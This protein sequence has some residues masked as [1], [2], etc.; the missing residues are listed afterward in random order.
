MRFAPR[1]DFRFIGGVFTLTVLGSG[2]AGNCALVTTDHCRLLV[3]AGLSA[4]Q[5][6]ERLALLDLAPEQL[7]AVLLT[8][9]HGDH[10]RALDVLCRR[11]KDVPIYCNALTAEILRRDSECLKSHRHWRVFTTGTDF[12][13]KDV[14]VQTF[15][16]PHDAVEPV[17]YMFHHGRAALGYLTDLGFATK[18]VHERVREATTLLIETNHDTALLNA[19]TRRPWSVK[20]RITSRHGHLSNEAAAAVVAELLHKGAKLKRTVLGH[21]SRDCNRPELAVETMRRQGGHGATE[22]EIIVASQN[23]ISARFTIKE[24]PADPPP[25]PEAENA[26][27]VGEETP[28]RVV[29]KRSDLLQLDLFGAALAWEVAR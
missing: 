19:D 13:I 12:E 26:G 18:L 22:L 11:F 16:V 5:T 9:E 1:A 28:P 23:D 21:L 2:S 3:D 25:V 10:C 15:A 4:R 17:G 20:Q 7:D 6:N 14:A 8:H 24:R 27:R 29:R